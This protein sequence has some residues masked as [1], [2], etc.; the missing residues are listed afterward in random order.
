[1]NNGYQKLNTMNELERLAER[2][3]GHK[4]EYSLNLSVALEKGTKVDYDTKLCVACALAGL[5]K[6]RLDLD[7][8]DL[9]FLIKKFNI[10][11]KR[12]SAESLERLLFIFAR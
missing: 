5:M 8:E 4:D 7:D 12:L 10:M 3:L 9:L 1:M 6:R 11:T 2:F